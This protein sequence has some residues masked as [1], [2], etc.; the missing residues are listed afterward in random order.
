MDELAGGSWLGIND[1]GVVAGILNRHGALGPAADRR[2]RGE[3]VLEALDHGDAIDAAHALANLE[4]R[5]YRPFNLVVADDRDAY[6][7][8][9]RDEGGGG[10]EVQPLPPGLSML[11]SYDLND[12]ASPR[13]RDYLPRFRDAVVPDPGRDDWRAWKRLLASRMFDASA[14]PSGAMNIKTENGFGT[15]SSSLIAIA[16]TAGSAGRRARWQFAPGPPDKVA[17]AEVDLG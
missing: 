2:S 17:Y 15:M 11:T 7:L 12:S 4:T 3:L 9:H 16:S 1:D 5:S 13:I 8:C 10:I 6:W 14:G